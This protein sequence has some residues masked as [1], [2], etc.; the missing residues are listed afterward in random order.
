MKATQNCTASQPVPRQPG[1]DLAARRRHL[2]RVYD[3]NAGIPGEV[4]HIKRQN[5]SDA[6][7]VHARDETGIVCGLARNF[8]QGDKPSPFRIGMI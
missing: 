2:R 3:V 1:D 4:L 6:V 5:V 7:N 8:V